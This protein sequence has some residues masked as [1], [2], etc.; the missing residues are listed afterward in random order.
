MCLPTHTTAASRS[1]NLVGSRV[2]YR[3]SGQ[4]TSPEPLQSEQSDP[5]VSS[6]PKLKYGLAPGTKVSP[7]AGHGTIP[8]SQGQGWTWLVVMLVPSRIDNLWRNKDL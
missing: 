1:C 5:S 3:Q 7:Q 8:P 6:P 2:R 4:T